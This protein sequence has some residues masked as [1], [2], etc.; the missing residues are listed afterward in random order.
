MNLVAT[1]QTLEPRHLL[2]FSANLFFDINQFGVSSV[3]DSLIEFNSEVFFVAND[4]NSGSELWKS[5]GTTEG[6]VRVADINPGPGGSLPEDLTVVGN[7][8]FFTAIDG[9]DE[10]DLW[11]SDGTEAGTVRV[12]DADAVDVFELSQLTA[13]GGN[14]F[15]TAYQQ[16]TGYELWV[17]DGTSTGTVL[18]K[19]INPDQLV[20]D[21]PKDLT[22]VDGT[23]FFTSYDNGYDNRELW[24][25]DGTA[26]GT[27]LVSDI[28]GNALTSSYPSQLTNVG[29]TLFF[30]A[31]A[32]DG[33]ELFKSNGT[34]ATTVQVADLNPGAGSSYPDSLT[35]FSGQLFFAAANG[36][37]GRQLFKSDGT[38]TTEVANTTPGGAG[39]SA[40]S[41]LTVVGNELFFV[42]EGG[43][44]PGPL[45]VTAP[46]LVPENSYHRGSSDY[47]G[48]VISTTNAA[49]G[50][51]STATEADRSFGTPTQGGT[52]SDGPGWI[53]GSLGIG[54]ISGNQAVGLSN[55]DV[56]DMVFRD[57]D[58]EA[59][60]FENGIA[61]GASWDWTVNDPLGLTN[62]QFAGFA[63][64]NEF[65]DAGEI[66]RFELFLNGSASA[67]AS[68]ELNQSA[69]LDNWFAGRNAN[70]LSLANA[71]GGNITSAT[72]RMTFPQDLPNDSTEALVIN[73]SLSATGAS[74]GVAGREIHKTDGTTTT[75]VKDIVS[76]GSSE[77]SQLTN[78]GGNLFFSANDPII[79]GRELWTSDGTE[80]GTVLVRDIRAGF[81]AYGVP[82]SGDPQ[83]L[84]SVGNTLFFSA[85]D[86][87][88]DRELWSSGGTQ[89]NTMLIKNIDVS[90]RDAAIQQV[91][92]VGN[93]L[94]FVADDGVNGEAVWEADPAAGTVNMVADV[95]ASSTDKVSGLAK[96]GNGVIFHND[97]LGIYT[98][99]GTNTTPIASINP[100]AFDTE[101][102][103]FAEANG[104]AFFVH[105][106]GTNGQELFRTNGTNGNMV[107]VADLREGSGGSDP[108]ELV[109]FNN[110][111][112]FVGFQQGQFGETGREVY[113][114]NG[115]NGA[116]LL[117]DI[118]SEQES[119]GGPI[120]FSSN[121]QGLTVS[122]GRLYFSADPGNSNG[123]NG[124]E[125]WSSDGTSFGTQLVFDIRT[126]SNDSNPTNLT[127]VGGILYFSANNGSQGFEPWKTD[128]TSAGTSLLANINP[129]NASSNADEFR[130]SGT[131]V[132]FAATDVAGGRELWKFDGTNTTLVEDLQTGVGSSN[133]A[134]LGDVG[135]GRILV[136]AVETGTADREFWIAG[137]SINGLDLALDMNPGSFFGSD[138]QSL[139]TI[140]GK[141]LFVGD[142]GTFGR[143]LYVLEEF[144]PEVE[145]VQ[146]DTGGVQRSSIG[147]FQV[148]FNTLV[149]V[150]GDAFEFRNLTTNQIAADTAVVGEVDGKTVVEFTFDFVAG[151]PVN[152]NGKLLDGDYQLT[153]AANGISSLGL[154]LDGNGDGTAGDDYVFGDSALDKFFRKFG[155][156]NGNNL[157]E[158]LDFAAFRGAFGS[159]EGDA[160]W[161]HAFDDD[162]DNK[163]L[164][165]DFAKFRGNFGS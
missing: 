25:S 51:L 118:N 73:A 8:L 30:T 4:G 49:S 146:I 155:D 34:S 68:M 24:K 45:V 97:S 20:P 156:G 129:G 89:A 94:F 16:A 27:V 82:L 58:V 44:V 85:I 143:E 69:D 105:N 88:D 128:G 29:G 120:T 127:D 54:G 124:R 3:P 108:R 141:T 160:N 53:D 12:F 14:L 99:D 101:G 119:L 36:T 39:S 158:L 23:L 40:P 157:V 115:T 32:S 98:Y 38:T 80:A 152:A 77:P 122:G 116:N 67:T 149:D 148:T 81:D 60:T 47:V 63:S 165:P 136:S 135:M 163:V 35:T 5:D 84:R 132:Y 91:V 137:G 9:D 121:P 144:A 104:F 10:I 100:V 92:Q 109:P 153:V 79:S 33:V 64:G 125:L 161:N 110:Q 145:S 150:T 90:T 37:T 13:S 147:S 42:A 74:S 107:L 26:V 117:K 70:N 154:A 93:K 28:D 43:T 15:F 48:L 106:D 61:A 87:A 75:L 162:G 103:L 22:D 123:N 114:T 139:V 126:G 17:S 95:T 140:G 21:G 7:E 86:D 151:G 62:I 18:V 11:K 113:F 52:S 159:S 78:V 138:P 133:P 19:D 65:S 164:L 111:L 131:D 130:Q 59:S 83:N 96:F 134:T 31:E 72:V 41:E 6:T 76:P 112:F 142:D 46:A 50:R 57:V 55:I 2:A 71:G 1:F 56:G 102:S 66:V